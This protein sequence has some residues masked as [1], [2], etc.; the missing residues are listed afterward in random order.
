MKKTYILALLLIVVVASASL[1]A[2][3]SNPKFLTVGTASTGGAF[4]PIGIAMADIITNK[5]GISTTAQI[6][7][8]AVENNSL[9]QMK[10]ADLAITMGFMAYNAVKGLD[11]YKNKMGKINV[12]FS[13]LS[14]GV[15]HI[16]VNKNSTIR[17]I[18]DL[19]GKRVALGPAGGG[20]IAVA[21]DV[22]KFYGL[23][24]GDIKP[25]YI[26]YEQ[27]TDA[28]TDGNIDAIAVQSAAPA[29]AITQL[30]AAKK[31]IRILNIE[32]SYLKK[33]LKKATYYS[34]VVLPAAMYG[35]DE[36]VT[37]LYTSLVVVVNKDMSKDLA[38]RITKALFENINTIKNS[39][40]SAKE[41]DIKEAVKALPAPLHPGA[42]KYFKEKGIL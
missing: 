9:V 17:S 14:K 42:A 16:V 22:F 23:T 18:K 41:L 4:Y 21:N 3:G 38:Y 13:G 10:T 30:T 34:K 2:A 6:T 35:T 27:A 31:P 20:A 15:F 37:T 11:P 33:I 28:L 1:S 26:S 36:P 25:V 32:D 8:G 24:A 7:G 5:V 19:K 12:L 39:H 29:P 40:P